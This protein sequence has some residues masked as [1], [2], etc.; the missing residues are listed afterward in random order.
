MV[1]LKRFF[2]SLA[3]AS[4]SIPLEPIKPETKP[5]SKE[6]LMKKSKLEK[7]VD[8][9]VMLPL[10]ESLTLKEMKKLK[11]KGIKKV[12]RKVKKG[13]KKVKKVKKKRKAKPKIKKRKVIEKRVKKKRIKKPK[14]S[15]KGLKKQLLK[16]EKRYEE[17][18]NKG[19]SDEELKVIKDKIGVI[20]K[21]LG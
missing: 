13:V 17:L 7:E 10:P 4:R 15:K 3:I 18:K 9:Y 1:S 2:R 6:E 5:K 12:K 14:I 11:L 20:K 16:I 19:Y 21:G 8:D